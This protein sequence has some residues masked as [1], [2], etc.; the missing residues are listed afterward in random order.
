MV[1]WFIPRV[2]LNLKKTSWTWIGQ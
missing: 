2:R 1:K